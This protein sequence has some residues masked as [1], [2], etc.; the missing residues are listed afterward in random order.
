MWHCFLFHFLFVFVVTCK[1][2]SLLLLR[3]SGVHHFVG[4]NYG[5]VYFFE[6]AYHVQALLVAG[7]HIKGLTNRNRQLVTSRSHAGL[8]M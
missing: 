3:F 1:L 4:I 2:F 6:S 5:D 8:N 7:C